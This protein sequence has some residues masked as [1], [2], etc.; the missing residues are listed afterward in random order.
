METDLSKA[1]GR[2]NDHKG[3]VCA[4]ILDSEGN[5]LFHKGNEKQSSLLA[6]GS[7][8]VLTSAHSL[9]SDLDPKDYLTFVHIG[10]GRKEIMIAPHSDSTLVV[11]TDRVVIDG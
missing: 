2:I 3:V 6:E 4:A 1:L 10:A 7:L 5:E 8:N 11:L 9:V